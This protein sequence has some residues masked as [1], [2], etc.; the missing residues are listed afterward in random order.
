MLGASEGHRE[1]QQTNQPTKVLLMTAAVA[2]MVAIVFG[3]PM[4]LVSNVQMAPMMGQDMGFQS[5][6]GMCPMLCGVPSSPPRLESN[7]FVLGPFPV[8]LILNPASN[9]RPVFHPPT[10]G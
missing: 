4:A 2:A 1:M 8:S 9:I 5:L 10:V 7:G 6:Q 3:C